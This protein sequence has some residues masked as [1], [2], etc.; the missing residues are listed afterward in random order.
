MKPSVTVAS[1]GLPF[2]VTLIGVGLVG[3]LGSCGDATTCAVKSFVVGPIIVIAI[4]ITGFIAGRVS[5]S[6]R[7]GLVAVLAAVAL[8][9][10]FIEIQGLWYRSPEPEAPGSNAGTWLFLTGLGVVLVLPGFLI[11]RSR[12]QRAAIADLDAQR[13]AGLISS[14]EYFREVAL[15]GRNVYHDQAPPGH[16]CGHCGKPLSPVWHGK[17]LHCGASYTEY[18]PVPRMS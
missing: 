3:L 10:A 4:P 12:H 16:R 8:V 18:P 17:C 11:G 14:D 6:S 5:S 7:I 9:V 13:A 2:L 15:R 1:F